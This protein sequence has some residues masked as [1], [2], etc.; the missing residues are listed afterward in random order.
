MVKYAIL[1]FLQIRPM[2]GYELS[3]N[4]N[5][6]INFFINIKESHIYIELKKMMQ[7]H[8]IT[9]QVVYDDK[10]KKTKKVY[11]IT[12]LGKKDFKYSFVSE[13]EIKKAS[14]IKLPLLTRIFHG[15][16]YSYNENIAI[17][18]SLL[19]NYEL[20]LE[21]IKNQEQKI[22]ELVKLVNTDFMKESSIYWKLTIDCGYFV[23]NALIEWIKKSIN[24]LKHL[25]DNS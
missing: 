11:S 8:L 1:G 16:Y 6:S 14:E 25:Q 24:A 17:L 18:K 4:I 3:K 19:K 2:S 10:T 9:E 13:L 20:K 15:K 23:Y 7:K 22:D 12:E 5:S 21:T